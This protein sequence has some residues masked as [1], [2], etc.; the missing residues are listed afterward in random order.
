MTA[1][2]TG[3]SG[4]IGAA[5]ARE[6][7]AH[8]NTVVCHYNKHSPVC[9][10]GLCFSIKA[11]L[12]HENEVNR[13][14]EEIEARFGGAGILV[15]NVGIALPQKLITETTAEEFDELYSVNVRGS[16]LCARRALP[17]MV[18]QK[19]GR[20]VNISSIWGVGGG[21]CEVAYAASKA[22]VVG[23]TRALADE[24][25]PSGVTVNCVAPGIIDTPMN[26]HLDL[27]ALA[28][29]I[30]LGRAGT[31]EDVAAA[32]GYF[33]RAGFVTGQVLVVD[34]GHLH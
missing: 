9:K 24:A 23:L 11:D 18:R 3:A 32:V 4:A 16:F 8:G 19:W 27:E 33:T 2:V 12:R 5:I 13:M 6:L 10:A 30:P 22:A 17:H 7:A 20:I 29:E 25:A 34:G 26:A 14:F 1:L 21:S 31:P 15:N 28:A